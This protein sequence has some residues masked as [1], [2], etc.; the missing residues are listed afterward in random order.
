[1]PFAQGIRTIN[2]LLNNQVVTSNATPADITGFNF[3][4]GAARKIYWALTGIF[5]LGATGG[6][7]FLAHFTQSP[8]TYNATFN[9]RQETTPSVFGLVQSAESVFANAAAV[10]ATYQ[11]HADGFILNGAT[12]GTF[13]FQIA[14]NT[15]DANSLTML[16]GATL[17]LWQF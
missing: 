9:I 2:V 8:T 4:L 13:S 17:Q 14:Q 7:R 16:A 3:V 10:A 11:L 6:F 1:M 12:S 5:T 15:V